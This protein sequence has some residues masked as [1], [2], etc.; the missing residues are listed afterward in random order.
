MDMRDS[1]EREN[2]IAFQESMPHL[3]IHISRSGGILYYGR[4][5]YDRKSLKSTKYEHL[6]E[7]DKELYEE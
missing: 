1:G 3:S 5:E 2:V 7:E 4:K 6:L